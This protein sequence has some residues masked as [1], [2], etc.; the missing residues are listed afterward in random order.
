MKQKKQI[1]KTAILLENISI[2]NIDTIRTYVEPQSLYIS[3]LL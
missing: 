3:F 2:A 1:D